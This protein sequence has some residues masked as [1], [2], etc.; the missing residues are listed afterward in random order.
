MSNPKK[1]TPDHESR[2]VALV[3]G[4]ATRVGAAIT[5]GL[6]NDGFRVVVHHHSSSEG[7]ERLVACHGDAVLP[8]QA[9]LTNVNDLHRL[10]DEVT[11]RVGP[12]N[13]LVCSAA[14][15]E[16]VPWKRAGAEH[17]LSAFSL[18]AMAPALMVQALGDGLATRGGSV[19]LITC[20][21]LARPY[22]NHAPYLASKAALQQLTRVLALELAP[23]V[24]VNAVAPGSVL[25]PEHSSEEDLKHLA[26]DTLLGRIGS[27]R[28]VAHAVRFLVSAPFVTGETI[29]VDGGAHIVAQRIR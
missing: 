11:R 14:N 4:G 28:D 3:T 6:V 19:V 8:L 29:L 1:S 21:S 15:Y 22:P 25:P 18:N 27:A 2:P 9:N 5:E 23:H 12:L 20:N 17:F 13:A 7:A 24:R 16:R 10:C 26:A